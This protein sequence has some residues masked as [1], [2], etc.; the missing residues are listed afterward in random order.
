MREVKRVTPSSFHSHPTAIQAVAMIRVFLQDRMARGTLVCVTYIVQLDPKCFTLWHQKST[1]C[2]P[3]LKFACYQK[4]LVGQELL[5]VLSIIQYRGSSSILPK[6]PKSSF[7]LFLQEILTVK[8][9][10]TIFF[11]GVNNG[12]LIPS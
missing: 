2:L 8:G 9:I 7:I 6:I 4:I 10:E 11:F 5:I 3:L 1:E 12:P